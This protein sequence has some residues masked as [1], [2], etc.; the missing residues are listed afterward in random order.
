M[1]A[2]QAAGLFSSEG[3][4]AAPEPANLEDAGMPDAPDAPPDPSLPK[5]PSVSNCASCNDAF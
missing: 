3:P 2:S 5:D 4:K 1:L